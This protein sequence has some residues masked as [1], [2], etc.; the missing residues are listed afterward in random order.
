MKKILSVL[1]VVSFVAVLSIQASQAFC[2]SDL[3][4][5]YWGHCP[6]CEKKKR[7]CECK[8]R[9]NDCE[10]VKKCDPCEQ[11]KQPCTGGA[12]PA[13]CPCKNEVQKTTI[14]CDPC[15]KLQEMNK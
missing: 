6:K 5:A 14:P 2:W 11:V 4:P 1:T 3:N 7:D 10:Q 13:K 8:K 12:A 15:D 9:E